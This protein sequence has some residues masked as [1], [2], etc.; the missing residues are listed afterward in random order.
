MFVLVLEV[1]KLIQQMLVV[2][3]LLG[4]LLL[5]ALVEI[6]TRNLHSLLLSF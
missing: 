1:R 4:D 2:N 6:L 3:T 5:E